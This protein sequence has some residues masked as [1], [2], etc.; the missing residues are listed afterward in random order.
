MRTTLLMRFLKKSEAN[1]RVHSKRNV[2][3]IVSEN[4]LLVNRFLKLYIFQAEKML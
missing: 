2:L 4:V 1:I 3:Q